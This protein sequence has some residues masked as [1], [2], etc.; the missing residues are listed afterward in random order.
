[1][2]CLCWSNSAV[3]T[4]AALCRS[5][6]HRVAT[7]VRT[8]PHFAHHQTSRVRATANRVHP[9]AVY[10]DERTEMA[11]A[12][13]KKRY[14]LFSKEDGRPDSEKPCAFFSSA[15][16]CRN[17]AKCKFMHGPVAL[18]PAPAAKKEHTKAPAPVMAPVAAPE[19]RKEAKKEKKEK[20]REPAPQAPQSSSVP[21]SN[22]VSQESFSALSA[23][24]KLVRE[25]QQQLK[26]QQA[27]METQM[28]MLQQ[29]M[30]QPVQ[31][32]VVTQHVQ[33]KPETAAKKDNKRKQNAAETAPAVPNKSPKIVAPAQ[34][35]VQNGFGALVQNLTQQRATP[36]AKKQP[37]QQVQQV[38]QPQVSARAANTYQSNTQDTESSGDDDNEFLFGAV[39]H[40]LNS[41][42]SGSN[43]S[44][45][46]KAD[47]PVPLPATSPFVTTD[48]A[49]KALHTSGSK[50]AL[51]GSA[52]K[53]IF[54]T[55][56]PSVPSLPA[57]PAVAAVARTRAPV[58]PFDPSE[59][60]LTVLPWT[61]LVGVTVAHPRFQANYNFQEDSTWVKAKP[62]GP[63]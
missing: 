11:D 12:A 42:L 43:T 51:H 49:V 1:M 60:D 7:R 59:A 61:Q 3:L 40:V 23:N 48:S 19:S 44:T 15:A 52:K 30:A 38:Q 46:Y 18:P 63:W 54:A 35:V 22:V 28:K 39:N 36:Q 6:F 20:R 4:D 24:D 16:G 5:P 58:V 37:A 62:Y 31:P 47:P 55:K 45:P 8:V 10:P 56:A 32:P 34:P 41:G 2:P 26:A 53:N 25:L 21:A 57:A 14:I 50:H 27:I 9:G 17:G 33:I 29:Q 13:E